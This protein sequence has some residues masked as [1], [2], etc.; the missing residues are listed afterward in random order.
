MHL[1]FFSRT[2][3]ATKGSSLLWLGTLVTTGYG[4][5][6]F[7]YENHPHPAIYAEL[8]RIRPAAE[9]LGW[10]RERIWNANFWPRSAE[11]PCW[12]ASLLESG[13]RVVEVHTD[14]LV[15]TKADGRARLRFRRLND[16]FTAPHGTAALSP[17]D[18]PDV[19]MN[20]ISG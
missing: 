14:H 17:A 15:F 20:L 2:C 18:I 19:F 7:A 11:H 4:A 9:Q 10:S 5:C 3:K 13:D 12:L 1:C 16:G 6:Q 8:E